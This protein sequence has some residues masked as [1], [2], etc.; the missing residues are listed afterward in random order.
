MYS[1][2][3]FS[4]KDPLGTSWPLAVTLNMF[5]DLMKSEDDLIADSKSE[6]DIVLPIVNELRYFLINV[7]ACPSIA[8]TAVADKPCGRTMLATR[9]I[10]TLSAILMFNLMP[11]GFLPERLS[12]R[13]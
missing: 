8:D 2:S 4:L 3:E 10:G 9:L 5:T 12:L 7:F 13:V 6:K 11:T 1:L